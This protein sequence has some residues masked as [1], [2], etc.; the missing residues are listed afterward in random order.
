MAICGE[1]SHFIEPE[2]KYEKGT[3]TYYN[4]EYYSDD[5]TCSHFSAGSS[6]TCSTCEYFTDP[7]SRYGR[8]NCSYYN[9]D[10]YPDE[11]AC[12]HYGRKS[13]GSSGCFLTTACCEYQGLP[14]NC[15]ELTVMRDFRDNYLYKQPYGEEIIRTYYQDAPKIVKYLNEQKNRDAIYHSIYVK[16]RS[17]VAAIEKQENDKAT[18]MYMNMVYALSRK[19][20]TSTV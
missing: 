11:S 14:D 17:I 20:F 18:I 1:C 9:K 16:I 2:N 15:H 8:G 6:I 12:S 5:R 7:D 3:C 19:A 4:C 13:S 10:Y